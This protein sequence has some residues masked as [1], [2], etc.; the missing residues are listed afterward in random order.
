MKAAK[1]SREKPP[2]PP[3]V[4]ALTTVRPKD[5]RDRMAVYM[6]KAS[7]CGLRSADR[8]VPDDD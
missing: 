8:R 6:F 3:K 2:Q 5:N 4:G 1:R 7:W